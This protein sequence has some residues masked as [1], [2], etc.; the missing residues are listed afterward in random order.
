MKEK[1][2]MFFCITEEVARSMANLNSCDN[3]DWLTVKRWIEEEH[4]IHERMAA[5]AIDVP[6][7]KVRFFQGM[8]WILNDLNAYINKPKEVWENAKVG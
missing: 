1:K 7:E 2:S 4:K 5:Y 8:A 6:A 3:Q